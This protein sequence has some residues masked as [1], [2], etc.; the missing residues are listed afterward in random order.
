[1][2]KRKPLPIWI[3]ALCSM[4]GAFLLGPIPML[5]FGVP[6]IV[7]IEGLLAGAAFIFCIVRLTNR[8]GATRR[9]NSPPDAD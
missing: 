5:M 1:M 4:A 2:S 6:V 3:W 9:V 7:A 8:R